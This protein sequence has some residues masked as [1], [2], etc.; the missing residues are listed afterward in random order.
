MTSLQKFIKYP[1]TSDEYELKKVTGVGAYSIVYEAIIKSTNMKVAIKIIDIN[2]SENI[3]SIRSE[4]SIIH[5]LNHQNI[6]SILTSFVDNHSVWI[7]MPLMSE[8]SCKHILEKR[9][10]G[11]KD[12]YLLATILK[13]V[14]SGLVYIHK[15]QYIHRDIK[16]CNILVS[17][18]VSKISDFGISCRLV[19]DGKRIYKTTFAGTP[20][21]M[22]PEILEGNIGYN[23][24]IDIWAFGITALELAYGKAPYEKCTPMKTMIQI[25]QNDPPTP[26]IYKDNS[27]KFSYSFHS[28]VRKCLTKSPEKRI[29]AKKLLEHKFFKR[30]K[31][32]AY[33]SQKLKEF[34]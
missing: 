2:L 32:S 22:A 18:G 14:L 33:V 23:E 31:D 6:V 21:W 16:G 29:C 17:D 13:D 7:V 28:M 25:L 12:E 3:D 10:K 8:G 19:K 5:M 9:P 1:E 4:I 34:F 24:K 26:E 15:N 27:Y 30:A 11:I 20:C